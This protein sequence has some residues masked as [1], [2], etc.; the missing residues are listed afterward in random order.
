[1]SFSIKPLYLLIVAL[2]AT[3]VYAVTDKVEINLKGNTPS[4]NQKCKLTFKN[5]N[6]RFAKCVSDDFK[7][8]ASNG[9]CPSDEKM[10]YIADNCLLKSRVFPDDVGEL[11]YYI[12]DSKGKIINTL[13]NGE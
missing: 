12:Y 9:A 3:N 11:Q 8:L 5:T 10:N 6:G 2:F 4:Q 1:M 13:N 7:I